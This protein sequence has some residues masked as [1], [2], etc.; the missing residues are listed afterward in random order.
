MQPN[1]GLPLASSAIRPEGQVWTDTG[2][3]EF[4]TPRAAS[5]SEIEEVVSDYGRAAQLALEVGF[6]GVERHGALG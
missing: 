4:V 3:Q 2:L 1:G 5:L 6:D